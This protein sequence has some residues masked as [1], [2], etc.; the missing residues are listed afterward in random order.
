M[1]ANKKEK[2]AGMGE[3]V[4][5]QG[6]LALFETSES[7][8]GKRGNEAAAE[9]LAHSLRERLEE[10]RGERG[11]TKA[12][13]ARTVKKNPAAVRR[14]LTSDK[15]NPELQTLIQL[16]GSV[17]LNVELVR[18]RRSYRRRGAGQASDSTTGRAD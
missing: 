10:A 8:R 11:L 12:D 15:F 3:A 14:L 4:S 13:I 5:G 7:S 2:P 16:A 17:G 9:H 18:E 1:P 6:Q